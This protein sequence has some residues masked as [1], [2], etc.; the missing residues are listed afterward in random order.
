MFSSV[1]LPSY[2]ALDARRATAGLESHP[3]RIEHDEGARRS[4]A[5]SLRYAC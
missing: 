5:P 2:T 4:V 1:A 3:P